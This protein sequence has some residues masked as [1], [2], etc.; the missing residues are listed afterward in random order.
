MPVGPHPQTDPAFFRCEQ[1]SRRRKSNAVTPNPQAHLDPLAHLLLD[2]LAA[3]LPDPASPDSPATTVSDAIAAVAHKLRRPAWCAYLVGGT[4]RDILAAPESGHPIQPRDIDIIVDGAT[5]DQLQQLLLPD[6]QLERRTR[7]G[8]L[9]LAQLLPSGLRVLFDIWTLADTWGFHSKKIPPR[10]DDFPSTTFLNIDSCA[11]ELLPTHAGPPRLFDLGFFAG[12][13]ART[14]D[15]NYAPNPYPYVCSARSLLL[16]ARLDFALARPL[17]EFI[18]HHAT[19]GGIPALLEAQISHYGMIRSAAPE[20][21]SWLADLRR[22]FEAAQPT[23]R[24][25]VSAA[26]RLQLWEDYP[27]IAPAAPPLSC[28]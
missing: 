10:I 22:Q 4:L 19:A 28:S 9:H 11:V 18:L 16:A 6:L 14:L 15:L 20:L 1:T 24:L 21:E 17:A 13:A 3:L 7:F 23:L 25:T 12:I 8:G 27:A 5:A 26:R 2:R